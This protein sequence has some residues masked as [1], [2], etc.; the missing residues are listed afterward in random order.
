MERFSPGASYVMTQTYGYR[1]KQEADGV[2]ERA[3]P[4]RG[5]G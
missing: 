2:C 4:Q 5:G 1:L 3:R